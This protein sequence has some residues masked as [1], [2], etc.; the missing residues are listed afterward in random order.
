MPRKPTFQK[1]EQWVNG[2]SSSTSRI[3]FFL[4]LVLL[5]SGCTASLR[6]TIDLD[7][8]TLEHTLVLEGEVVE[9]LDADPAAFAALRSRV[10]VWTEQPV[11]ESRDGDTLTYTFEGTLPLATS[12]VALVESSESSATVDV[13]P[14]PGLVSAITEAAAEAAPQYLEA[15]RIELTVVTAG[16]LTEV[17]AV[18]TQTDDGTWQHTVF[19][20]EPELQ[21]FSFEFA[22]TG[23]LPLVYYVPLVVAMGALLMILAS[24][25]ED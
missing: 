25:R 4:V 21:S 24:R 14:P 5:L 10:A 7:E 12:G 13:Q 2:A 11:D 6:T 1:A 16:S 9:A 15:T 3:A 17:P 22:P 18:G 20:N 8:A 23:S 19:F